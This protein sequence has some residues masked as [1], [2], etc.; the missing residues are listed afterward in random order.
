MFATRQRYYKRAMTKRIESFADLIAPMDEDTFFAEFHDKKPLHI[1]AAS[2][3]KLD[4]VMTWDTLTAILNMTAIWSPHSLKL[5]MDTKNVPTD[6]YCR[7]AIDRNGQQ[8]MQPDADKVKSWLRRGAS[9][10][11][12][13]IDTLT[14]G[15][16]SAANAVEARLG[17]KVQSNLYCS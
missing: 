8:S 12:N 2:P 9:I 16:I 3:D 13:D 5:V 4:D 1:Q 15:L 10:V 17:G 11:A 6:Q 7:P 14:P